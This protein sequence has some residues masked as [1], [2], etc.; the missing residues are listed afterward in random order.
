MV[1]LDGSGSGDADGDAITYLWAITS[2][3]AASKAVLTNPTSVNPS[4]VVDVVGTF[5]AE[6]I[7]NDSHFNSAPSTVT[8][9]AQVPNVTVP[10]LVGLSQSAAT[11]TLSASGFLL[12]SVSPGY[13]L[14]LAPGTVLSQ[15]PAAV[16]QAPSGSSVNI[17]VV[18]NLAPVVAAPAPQ[19]IG[20]NGCLSLL[21]N[22]SSP[23]GKP[24]TFALSNA[25]Q[26]CRSVATGRS[27]FPHRS[28][29]RHL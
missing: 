2:S 29:G 25:P 15:S 12:G 21:I 19:N 11:S 4:F 27:C 3:P 18:V 16:S 10:N 5:V 22:A 26:A 28:A 13:N 9:T 8:I 1:V 7:V 23:E 6:L 24:L 17:T 20:I 14:T